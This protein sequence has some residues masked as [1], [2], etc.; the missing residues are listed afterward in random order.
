[1]NYIIDHA[2]INEINEVLSMG[3]DKVTANPTMYKNNNTTL[4]DFIDYYKNKELS[5]L[6]AEVMGSTFEEMKQEVEIILAYYPDAI[7]KIN[8]SKEG[9][10]LCNYLHKK[11]I[12]T[13]MTLVFS[14][15]QVLAAINAHTDYIFCFVGRN[16]EN[17]SDG[18]QFLNDA[19]HAT[20]NTNTK[21]VAASIKNLFQLQ[22]LSRIGIPYAAIPYALYMKSL[23]HPLTNSGAQTF[24]EDW[25]T[26]TQ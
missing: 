3:I 6:S 13:A 4:Q 7:I 5:F 22:E 15:E 23:E 16:D 10:K 1:M 9:L 14:L 18:L 26:Q 25:K 21:I 2:N 19:H 20:N 24:I 17:G 11:N 8:F 12:K